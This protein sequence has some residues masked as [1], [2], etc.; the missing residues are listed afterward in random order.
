MIFVSICGDFDPLISCST[1]VNVIG[2]YVVICQY[3]S[4]I[5]MHEGGCHAKEIASTFSQKDWYK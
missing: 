2:T 1:P 3:D 5:H 4:V